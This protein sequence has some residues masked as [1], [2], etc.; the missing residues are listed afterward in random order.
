MFIGIAVFHNY[1]YFS[2]HFKPLK[3]L[4]MRS[5]LRTVTLSLMS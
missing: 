3:A 4:L 2:L 5:A 1:L